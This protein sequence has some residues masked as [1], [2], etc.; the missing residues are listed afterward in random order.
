MPAPRRALWTIVMTI[1]AFGRIALADA[2]ATTQAATT[3]P[4]T[5][6]TAAT[7]P[8]TTQTAAIQPSAADVAKIDAA[9]KALASDS[10]KE[11][12][13]AQETL[14]SFGEMALPRLRHLAQRGEDE[15]VRTRAGAA[16]R[17]IEENAVTGASVL[18]L[19]FKDA[20]PKEVFD[21]IAKQAHCEFA[22]FPPDLW[23][24][25]KNP[26]AIT[27]DLERV[28][29]WTAFKDVCQKTGIYP[30]QNG[31][32]RRMTLQQS[33]GTNFWNGPSVVSGPFLIVA[34]RIY[35]SN[36]VDLTNPGNA[37]QHDCNMA[38]YA[39]S[40][41]KIKVIQ[42]SY[43]VQVEEAVDEKGNSLMSN[44]R[45]YTS[46][47]SG[48]QW[49]WNLNAHLN[50][51]ENA[52]K[53]ITRFKGS[54]KFLIQTRSDTLDVPDILTVKN[55]TKTVARR[56]MLV[57]QCTKQN[58]EQ[59]E[60]QMTLYRDGLSQADWDAV[61]NPG[62][63]VHLFDKDGHMLMSNGWGTNGS[64]REMNYNWTF[65]KNAW[66]PQQGKIG[67]PHRLVWEIPVETREMN[68]TFE[69]KDLPLP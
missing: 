47:N 20:K 8:A 52:G 61:Q 38:L 9:I 48:Q 49:M 17:S 50:Y 25:N 11:R 3:R 27:L 46:M 14:V 30:Q 65:S 53:K 37:V 66:G 24:Q 26:P 19:K 62:Y 5:T 43:Y 39:F 59:F 56:R 12:N 6:Q 69:F 45:F 57:K 51:P 63:S 4:A 34:N 29:F 2:P 7:Q 35:R 15:E 64:D 22:T 1:M 18:T 23:N 13:K 67:D 42:S 36:S 58:G 31:N 41:P 16:A 55:L 33:P 68:V 10:W 28:N 21:E 54:M 44:D 32:D 40:E 60:L